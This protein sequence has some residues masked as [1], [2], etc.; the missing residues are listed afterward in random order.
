[1]KTYIIILFLFSSIFSNAQ[2]T[3]KVID[4]ISKKPIPYVNIWIENEPY[5]T[6]SEEDG[7][8]K[9]SKDFTSKT[10]V[11]SAIGYETKKIKWNF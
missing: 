4:S 9:F 7:F 1:M 2:I 3:G 11:F 8:F 10:I 5:G 6:T